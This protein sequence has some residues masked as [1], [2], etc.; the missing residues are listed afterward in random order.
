MYL[1]NRVRL[2]RS[3]V[4]MAVQSWT[5]RMSTWS[6]RRSSSDQLR[7]A[8]CFASRSEMGWFLMR[9][10]RSKLR[11]HISSSKSSEVRPADATASIHSRIWP[12]RNSDRGS[13]SVRAA[14]SRRGVDMGASHYTQARQSAPLPT[15]AASRGRG[16]RS[17]M[18]NLSI[19]RVLHEIADILEIKGDNTFRIRSYRMGAESVQ[20]LAHDLA[21]MVARGE[22]LTTLQ[23]VGSGIAGK[24]EELVKSG[25]CAY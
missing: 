4:R 18:D 10:K 20:A 8:S 7:S 15:C 9:K 16:K 1:S 25:V 11:S 14:S 17:A 22:K 13:R 24:I 23:G 3:S 2:T 19:A 12:R 6:T 21:G 5:A